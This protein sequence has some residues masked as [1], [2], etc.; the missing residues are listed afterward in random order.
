M[1][2]NQDPKR[3]VLNPIGFKINVF[4]GDVIVAGTNGLFNNLYNNE[5]YAVVVHSVRAGFGPHVAAQKIDALARK[6]ALD[7]NRQT[8]FATAAQDAGFRYHGGVGDFRDSCP[9]FNRRLRQS[10]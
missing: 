9:G 4:P 3:H 2:T 8:S 7:K 5:I 1:E 10:H 6:T